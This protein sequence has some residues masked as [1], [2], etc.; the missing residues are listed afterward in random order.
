MSDA[1]A[2]IQSEQKRQSEEMAAMRGMHME[3]MK[4]ITSLC[5]KLDVLDVQYRQSLA[6]NADTK[7]L[8]R[9]YGEKIEQLR[10][11]QASNE[12]FMTQV[13]NL[14]SK[15]ILIVLGAMGSV[16]AAAYTVAK[17]LPV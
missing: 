1:I 5:G 4:G 7:A 13:K 17:G 10:I 14:N 6:D 8:L 12:Y 15:A 16:G 2:A 9:D 11:N 3:Q